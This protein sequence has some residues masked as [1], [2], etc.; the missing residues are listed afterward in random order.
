MLPR[1]KTDRV[2]V[3]RA[4]DEIGDNALQCAR[5]VGDQR[6]FSSRPGQSSRIGRDFEDDFPLRS[7]KPNDKG[8]G[9]AVGQLGRRQEEF[10]SKVPT[11][12][13]DHVLLQGGQAAGLNWRRGHGRIMP[14]GSD[15]PSCVLSGR[16]RERHMGPA[17]CRISRELSDRGVADLGVLIRVV[18]SAQRSVSRELPRI[19]FN[20]SR[21]DAVLR[22]H[23]RLRAVVDAGAPLTCPG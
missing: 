6:D 9:T 14:R 7:P 2:L 17:R 23:R 5:S 15:T 4:G 11:V 21:Q 18:T 20:E 22:H 1:D 16:A 12:P 10:Q 8:S 3:R 19:L 13:P